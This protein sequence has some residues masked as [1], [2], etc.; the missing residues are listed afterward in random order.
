MDSDFGRSS[1][2][3]NLSAHHTDSGMMI[4]VI[5]INMVKRGI[6]VIKCIEFYGPSQSEMVSLQNKIFSGL[7]VADTKF[8]ATKRSRRTKFH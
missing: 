5:I 8:G 1:L 7:N 6:K 3:V 2:Y 4:K